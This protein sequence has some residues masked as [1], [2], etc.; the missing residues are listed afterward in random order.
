MQDYENL[1]YN[2]V[3]NK[4]NLDVRNCRD[5]GY[6]GAAEMSGGLFRSVTK[7]IFYCVNCALCTLYCAHN[8]MIC[9]AAKLTQVSTNFFTTFQSILTQFFSSSCPR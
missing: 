6:D 2:V 1:I 7:N 3:I 4:F 5:Q 8:L 9:D